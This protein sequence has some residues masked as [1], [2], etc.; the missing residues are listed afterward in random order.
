MRSIGFEI[1][2]WCFTYWYVAMMQ[3]WK[4]GEGKTAKD[5]G[6]LFATLIAMAVLLITSGM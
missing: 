5:A 3:P 1:L 6:V 4:K 2:A